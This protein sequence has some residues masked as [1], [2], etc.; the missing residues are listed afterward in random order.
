MTS[1]TSTAEKVLQVLF[2]SVNFTYFKNNNIK[3]I[4]ITITYDKVFKRLFIKKKNYNYNS[5]HFVN[6]YDINNKRT[7]VQTVTIII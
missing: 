4:N 3:A 7:Q 6:P 5:C 1:K 2:I